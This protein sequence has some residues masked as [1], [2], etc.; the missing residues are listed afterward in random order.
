MLLT[1]ECRYCFAIGHTTKYCSVLADNKKKDEKKVK[2]QQRQQTK[3]TYAAKANESKQKSE[4]T[5]AMKNTFGCLSN[6][7]DSDNDNEKEKEKEINIKGFQSLSLKEQ[8]RED[9]P[10][11]SLSI[12]AP[13][14]MG[15]EISYASMAS[16]SQETYL[17][18]NY[19][20]NLLERSKKR[21]V[22]ILYSSPA[23]KLQK[24]EADDEDED[25]DED[26]EEFLMESNNF[27]SNTVFKQPVTKS[28][29]DYDSEDE[30]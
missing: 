26:D 8:I 7:T 30:W 21:Q 11:L 15:I 3:N 18:E 22:P 16:K 12:T 2:L 17:N 10:A 29:A 13:K 27:V 20:K 4:N 14:Q 9:F 25:D 5:P 6:D 24:Y 1:T 23:K 28:W 19:E